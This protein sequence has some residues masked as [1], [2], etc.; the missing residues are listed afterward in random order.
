[1]RFTLW[2][3]LPLSFLP[4]SA[5]AIDHNNL[6]EGRPLRIEDAYPIAYGELS[7]EMGVGAQK[8]RRNPD[9]AVFPLEILYGAY[10]NLHLGLGSTLATDPRTIDEPDKSGDLRAFALYN[11]N[12]ETWRLPALAAKL[13]L[14]FPT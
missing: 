4:A 14:E 3:L 5:L 6:D 13:S 8:N 1:M 9:R 7:A 12:Q 2:L 11:F 10:W